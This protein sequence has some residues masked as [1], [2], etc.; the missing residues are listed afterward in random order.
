MAITSLNLPTTNNLSQFLKK[1]GNRYI[2]IGKTMEVHI[3]SRYKVYDYLSIGRSVTTLGI[4]RLIVNGNISINLSILGR[5]SIIPSSIEEITI[6]K[7]PYTILYLNNG[8]VFM[9]TDQIIQDMTCIFSSI[10]EF[11]MYARPLYC[12]S[13]DSM[14]LIYDRVKGC[15]GAPLGMDRCLLEAMIAYAFR[16]PKQKSVQ[17]RFSDLSEIPYQI[18]LMSIRESPDS[19]TSRLIG[20]YADDGETAA[21]LVD[22]NENSEFEDLLRGIYD[23]NK[24]RDPREVDT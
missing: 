19:T 8:D 20:P 1:E 3:P 11:L 24:N 14:S 17:Y 6:N 9:E 10:L 21:L 7:Y 4:V 12:V 18:A 16:N 13:Y 22:E 15:T 5:I 2:F 23:P